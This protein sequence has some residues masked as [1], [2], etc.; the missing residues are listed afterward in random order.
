M[1]V[2]TDTKFTALSR[3]VDQIASKPAPIKGG[4]LQEQSEGPNK[5]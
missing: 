2:I 4:G 1:E 3:N 5:T